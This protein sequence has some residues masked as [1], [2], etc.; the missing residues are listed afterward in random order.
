MNKIVQ[1]LLKEGY[2]QAPWNKCPQG[3][4]QAKYL[5]FEH[6]DHNVWIQLY[7]TEKYGHIYLN[8]YPSGREFQTVEQLKNLL[9]KK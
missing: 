1:L 6:A 4:E 7:P 9:P 5:C 2:T 8:E 3:F